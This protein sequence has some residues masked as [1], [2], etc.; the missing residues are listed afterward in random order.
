MFVVETE[1]LS[2]QQAAQIHFCCGD[3]IILQR[4]K[5]FT[6]IRRYTWSHLS[7]Q[8]IATMLSQNCKGLVNLRGKLHKRLHCGKLHEWLHG[9]LHKRLHGHLHCGRFHEWLHGRL[10]EWLHGQLHCG[11]LHEWLHGRLYCGQLHD[12]VHRRLHGRVWWADIHCS[13]PQAFTPFVMP[14]LEPN[15][16]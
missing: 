16:Q 4:L 12:L 6:K 11:R 8:H 9:R 13:R 15:E 7:L 14:V 1:F 2:P 5:S 3:K 10:Y